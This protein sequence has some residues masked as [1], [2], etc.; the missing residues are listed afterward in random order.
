MTD[1]AGAN[2]SDVSG[3][4]RCDALYF[5]VGVD[6]RHGLAKIVLTHEYHLPKIIPAE[7]DHSSACYMPG[8]LR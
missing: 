5:D 2:V 7:L 8:V 6:L 3:T 4:Q 1:E